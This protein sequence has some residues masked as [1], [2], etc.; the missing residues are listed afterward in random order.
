MRLMAKH[1]LTEQHCEF[2]YVS[3]KQA[4]YFNPDFRNWRIIG[5]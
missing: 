1:K 4:A 5:K 3:I 2:D